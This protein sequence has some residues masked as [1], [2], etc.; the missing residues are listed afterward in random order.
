MNRNFAALLASSCLLVSL[1]FVPEGRTLGQP[2]GAPR[3][4]LKPVN[5]AAL[6]TVADEDDPYLSRDGTRLFYSCNASKQFTLLV[7]RQ[8][9]RLPG[10]PGSER[11]PIGTEVEGPNA[12]TDSRSPFVTAD[13]HDLYYAEKTVVKAP[14]GEPQAAAN[15]EIVHSIRSDL[16]NPTR[17]TGPTFVQAVCTENDELHPWLSEDGLELYFSRKTKDGWRVYVATRPPA[18]PRQPRGAFGQPREIKELPAGFHHATLSRD[19]KTMY[20]QGPLEQR[21]GLFRSTRTSIKQP[22]GAPHLLANLNHPEAATGDQSPCLSRDG[23]RLYFS[24]DRPGGKGGRDLW[25][26]ET[27]WLK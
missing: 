25:V 14:P 7:S 2:A 17:F 13:G 24:S 16:R 6:N 26:I 4:L 10:F 20:L 15:F 5:L 12:D 1:W 22:W 11:W 19:G 9:N 8:S 27:V 21:W 18:A 3:G 23:S